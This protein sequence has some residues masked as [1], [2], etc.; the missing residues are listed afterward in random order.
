[1]SGYSLTLTRHGGPESRHGGGGL[2][3]VQ[4]P[5]MVREAAPGVLPRL[6]WVWFKRVHCMSG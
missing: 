5:E 3:P 1:M 6:L 4:S 2:P